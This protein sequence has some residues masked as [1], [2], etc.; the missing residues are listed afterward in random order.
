MASSFA[1]TKRWSWTDLSYVSIVVFL[2]VP[3]LVESG[4]YHVLNNLFHNELYAGTTVG[5]VMSIIFIGTLYVVVL[6]P[7]RQGFD[8]VG[9]LRFAKGDWHV[10]IRLTFLL[11]ILSIL[12][13]ILMSILGVGTDN[14]KTMSLQTQVTLMN[15][16]IAF[17]SA[18]IIS[19]V[20]EEIFY[21]GFLF[22]FFSNRYGVWPG[23]LISSAIFTL[24]HL[25]TYNTL[26]VNFVSGLIFAWA[27]EKTGSVIPSM[28]IHGT[29]NGIAI[30]LTTIL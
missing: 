29:F 4:L 20:Y 15:V 14:S 17:V 9:V 12:L 13:V 21:R 26:P 10:I 3:I 19:P 7:N 30:L 23:M 24:A 25:P 22:R 18:A 2:A 11:I 1:Q 16:F 6:Q 28:I 8:T 27:Y 5:L